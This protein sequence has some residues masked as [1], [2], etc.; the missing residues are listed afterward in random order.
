MIIKFRILIAENNN[1]HF[2]NSKINDLV[3]LDEGCKGNDKSPLD[4]VLGTTQDNRHPTFVNYMS[5][6][7]INQL[8][9]RNGFV[10]T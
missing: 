6:K 5:S 2:L 4:I 3:I 8:Q 1:D 7:T 9:P 10:N